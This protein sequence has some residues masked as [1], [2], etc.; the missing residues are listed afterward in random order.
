MYYGRVQM[1][2]NFTQAAQLGGAMFRR[3]AGSKRQ[4]QICESALCV[5]VRGGAGAGPPLDFQLY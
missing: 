5:C 3:A 1:E 4:R 2:G